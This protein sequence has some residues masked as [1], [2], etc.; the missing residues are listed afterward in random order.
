MNNFYEKLKAMDPKKF[1]ILMWVVGIFSGILCWAALRAGQLT[2]DRLLNW[3]FIIV[4][5]VIMLGSNAIAKKT[6]LNLSKFRIALAV[7][8]GFCIVVFG[9]TLL[10]TGSDPQGR[11]G[12]VEVLFD[13]PA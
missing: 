11:R 8:L 9:V 5:A 7:G 6:G 1:T 2:E 12:L 4:F 10:I 3:A 13:L